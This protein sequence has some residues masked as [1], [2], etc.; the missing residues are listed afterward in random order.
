MAKKPTQK[1]V[2]VAGTE[3][4]LQKLVPREWVKLKTRTKDKRG[5]VSE[6]KFYDEILE[7]IVVMPKITLDDFELWEDAE[8]VIMAAIEFQTGATF[9]E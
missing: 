8:A 7:H 1:K 6:E 4:T 3:Y 5:D 2:E 9:R